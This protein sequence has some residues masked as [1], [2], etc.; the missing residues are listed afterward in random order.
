MGQGGLGIGW[1]GR[2]GNIEMEIDG[3]GSGDIIVKAYNSKDTSLY[4]SPFP[5]QN[6]L[7]MLMVIYDVN[8]A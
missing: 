5:T 3:W 2:G 7:T 4:G 6:G 1:G 8:M